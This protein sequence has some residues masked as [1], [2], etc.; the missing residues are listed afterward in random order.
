MSEAIIGIL[1]SITGARLEKREWHP[2]GTPRAV[3]QLV[4]G[5]AEHIARYDATAK[6]LNEAGFLVVG[7]TQLGHGEQAETLGWFAGRN[8]WDALIEDVDTLRRETQQAYPTVPYFL[9]GH[10]LGSLIVRT[11]CLKYE[12]GLSGVILSATGHFEA[13]FLLLGKAIAGVQCL[14]G[15]EKK[16]SKLLAELNFAGYNRDW[17]PARTPYD[18]LSAETGNVDRYMADPYCGFTCTAGGYRDMS[19]GTWRLMPANLSVMDK[20]VPVYLFS[21]KDD[22]VGARG[23]GVKI[24]MRELLDAGVKDVSMKLYPGGR[25]EMLNEVQRETVWNDLIAWIEERLGK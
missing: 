3:V 24:T 13:P 19:C 21:G 1:P 18:W 9:L 15:M 10:S 14:F 11:Y 20:D 8:G 12:T 22:P 5:M 2:T 16:P 6:R 4:H 17:S 23:E 7:H 25:H